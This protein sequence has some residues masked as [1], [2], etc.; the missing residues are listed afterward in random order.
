MAFCDMDSRFLDLRTL[1]AALGGDISCGQVLCPGPNHSKRDRSLAVKPTASGVLVYSHAGDDW[2]DCRDYVHA[3]LGLP[4][5]QPGNHRHHVNVA[6]KWTDPAPERW[7][8]DRAKAIW[9]EGREPRG[10]AAEEYLAAR[11]LHLPSELCNFV[12]RFH[13]QCLWEN[14][15]TPCLI[16][17]FTSI[18][19][20]TITAIHRIRLDRPERWP[21]TERKMFG[22]VAGS[23]V[24][25][26]LPGPRL[27][28]A[29]GVESALAARQLGFGATWALGSARR[30]MPIDGVKEL[31]IL[32]ERD[33]ASRKATDACSENWIARGRTVHLALPAIGKDFN[34]YVMGAR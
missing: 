4:T 18:A 11:S 25:F 22:A 28:I 32:G 19:D 34:D 23:A 26:D 14:E 31:I 24:K 30:F 12:L 20:N 9:D 21:K 17:A 15:R 1:Q 3:R 6:V 33:D 27:A 13:P 29:E 7:R 8:T 5:W 16:A 10:T 2:R